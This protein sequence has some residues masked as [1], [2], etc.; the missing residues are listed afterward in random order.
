[1]I[2]EAFQPQREAGAVRVGRRRSLTYALSAL[3]HG[4]LIGA[5]LAYSFWSVDEL[6]PPPLHVTLFSGALP[7]APPPPPPPPGAGAAATAPK[8]AQTTAPART[9]TTRPK[10]PPLVQPKAQPLVQ[11]PPEE[12]R[13][14]PKAD[15][16]GGGKGAPGA[17]GGE[18]GGVAGGVAGGN[19]GNTGSTGGGSSR[20]APAAAKILPGYLGKL[21]KERC[22]D[23]PFPP[24]LNR[25]GALYVA[26]AKICVSRAGGVD[27]VTLV[28]RADP[29]LDG[30]VL[31]TVKAWRYR[32]LMDHDLSIPFCYVDQLE[33]RGHQ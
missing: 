24:I 7:A 12:P 33:F 32:P 11:P 25:P 15:E 6:A 14:E 2:F 20:I 17:A 29:L 26:L 3:F 5:G 9:A 22:P 19:P 8:S 4:A 10:T 21:Q 1:M 30:N 31:A 18:K 13:P 27:S 23:P 28:K 16:S